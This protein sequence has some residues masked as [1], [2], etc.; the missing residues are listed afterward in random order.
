MDTDSN[1]GSHWVAAYIENK[2]TVKYFD[3]FGPLNCLYPATKNVKNTENFC[4]TSPNSYIYSFLNKYKS[5]TLNKTI[6]QSISSNNCGYFCIYFIYTKSKG[7]LFEKIMTILD[8]QIDC[9][10][11]VKNF[12]YKLVI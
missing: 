2:E 8:N 11:F 4:Y 6:Y 9:N 7:I 5:I 10:Y 1:K 12:V 3:S